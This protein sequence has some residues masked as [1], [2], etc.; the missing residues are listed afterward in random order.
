MLFAMTSCEAIAQGSRFAVQCFGTGTGQTDRIK[1]PLASAP[2]LNVGADFTIA[3]WMRADYS[4]NAG[5]VSSGQNG[6]GWITGNV[7]IDRDIYG[8]GDYG[9][10]GVS[11]GRSA[12]HNVLA[13][14]VHNGDWGETIVGVNHVGD[15]NWHHVAVTREASNG[16]LRIVVDG[17]LDAQGAGPTGNVSYRIG[18]ETDWPD[19]DPYLVL[20]AEKHDAGAEYPS[21]SGTL[22]ELRIWSRALGTS[23]LVSVA[24]QIVPP[25]EAPGLVAWFRLEEGA[26]QW[27]RDSVSGYTGT[28]FSASPGNGQWTS[29]ME[30][31]HAAPMAPYLPVLSAHA[32]SSQSLVIRWFALQNIEYMVEETDSLL[33]PA[34]WAPLANGSNVVA[35][36]ADLAITNSI[37]ESAARR[38]FRVKGTPYR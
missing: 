38:F 35:V 19:S 9:D 32:P 8:P 22:D 31:N 20:G 23:E 6:D 12:G 2:L 1:I 34:S 11:I 27:L 10:F 36:D 16:L 30:G 33:P 26:H 21:F 18:R 28:L 4:N 13:F 7:V 24:S 17:R 15:G 3:F 25:S 37:A 14:G 29:W 5:V